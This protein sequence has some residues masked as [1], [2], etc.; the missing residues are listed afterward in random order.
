[1]QNITTKKVGVFILESLI[2]CT[3]KSLIF[4]VVGLIFSNL[5]SEEEETTNVLSEEEKDN[6]KKN[7]KYWGMAYNAGQVATVIILRLIISSIFKYYGI[8]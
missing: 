2:V 6:I 8:K 7:K 3:L 1:M 5:N 4:Y